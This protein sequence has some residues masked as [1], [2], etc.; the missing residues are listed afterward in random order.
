MSKKEN[1]Y[2]SVGVAFQVSAKVNK[3]LS[4]AA[5]RS[6]RP[7]SKEA[8]LRLADHL[9]KFPDIA[10]TGRRFKNDGSKG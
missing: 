9:E 3:L 8:A 7:K 10:T 2:P 6:C 4:E 1:E 5:E